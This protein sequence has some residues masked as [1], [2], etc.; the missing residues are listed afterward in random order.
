MTLE[1]ARADIDAVDT[2]MK[3]LFLKRMECAKKV[4]EVKAETGGDVFVLERELSII[5]KRAGDVDPEVYDE[6]VTFL[7]HLMS[8][9]RRYQ[10]GKLTGMQDSVVDGAAKEAGIDED[11][12][13]TK[14]EISF[15]CPS[16][17]SDLNLFINMTKLNKIC[18]NSMDLKTEDGVQKITMTLDGNLKESNMRRLLCQIGKEADNFKI[19]A[20]K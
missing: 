5:E 20:V 11:A 16:E 9:S 13:H 17:T 14:V 6:Y 1:E 10:Y 15:T 8:V 12:K 18:I 19:L 2:Q 4:A 3:P 7:R